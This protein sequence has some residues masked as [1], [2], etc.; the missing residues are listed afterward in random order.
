[1]ASDSCAGSSPVCGTN[2][3]NLKFNKI[4][5][6]INNEV[7]VSFELIKLLK[8]AG[9]NLECRLVQV[10]I[11]EF[12]HLPTLAVVQKWL[13]EVK[14]EYVEV[15]PIV[16]KW[17]Y[18]IHRSNFGHYYRDKQFKTYEEAQEA[19]IKKVLEIILEKKSK[20]MTI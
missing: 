6:I 15:H 9:F 12:E 16:N 4:M 3:N 8:Q 14:H 18:S 5:I 10:K 17:Y 19:S 13:R 2:I 20:T 7:Y 1:M 11:G